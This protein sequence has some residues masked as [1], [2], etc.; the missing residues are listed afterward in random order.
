MKHL[1]IY[2]HPYNGSFNHAIKEKVIEAI[3]AKGDSYELRDLYEMNFNPVLG[4]EELANV[5]KGIV[6]ADVKKE[7][8]YISDCDIITVIFPIWWSNSPAILKGYI[9]RVFS[10]GFAYQYTQKGPEGLL[11][12]KK[13]VVISTHGAMEDQ[14]Q[15]IG[16]YESF[17][18]TIDMGIFQFC[19][20][21]IL[22]HKYLGGAVASTPEIRESFLNE[23]AELY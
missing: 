19:G 2:A 17:Q 3:K 13:S 5:A 4:A 15:A 21:E 16:M 9:D 7:Q 14:Y 22:A 1:I 6:S 18:K 20:M 10:H 23:V 8:D 12:G 11:A